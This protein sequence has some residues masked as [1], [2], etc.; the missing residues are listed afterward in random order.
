MPAADV[1]INIG[2]IKANKTE[3]LRSK[4]KEM[5]AEMK[6]LLGPISK[7]PATKPEKEMFR[8]LIKKFIFITSTVS[9][10][11][12]LSDI[13]EPAHE[14]FIEFRLILGY[15]ERNSTKKLQSGLEDV[16]VMCEDIYE[17]FRSFM[18]DPG[19][20]GTD[21][22]KP[23]KLRAMRELATAVRDAEDVFVLGKDKRSGST[24][25]NKQRKAE[26]HTA[27]DIIGHR[28]QRPT[29]IDNVNLENASTCSLSFL[30]SD[31]SSSTSPR[32]TPETPRLYVEE[33]SAIRSVTSMNATAVMVA[34]MNDL[35]APPALPSSNHGRI[36][37]V[38]P[39][40]NRRRS[41]QQG[42]RPPILV[43]DEGDVLPSTGPISNMAQQLK[44]AASS[45]Y[46]S[47]GGRIV[48]DNSNVFSV[49]TP[50]GLTPRTRGP[51][52]LEDDDSFIMAYRE[53]ANVKERVAKSPAEFESSGW[54]LKNRV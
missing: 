19:Y 8:V 18:N 22:P 26:E 2:K 30:Y 3:C 35:M 31:S 6:Q 13:C 37:Y 43:D 49:D 33:V 17:S 32:E 39:R 15:F 51:S 16:V 48:V 47:S 11:Y 50:K 20:N 9:D 42:L 14:L 40:G 25:K 44:S 24:V 28:Q 10:D 52:L 4:H 7:L 23:G 1:R 36:S 34:A 27:I 54:S 38:D 53:Y 46:E 21:F 41:S 12:F 45:I 29:A 5:L